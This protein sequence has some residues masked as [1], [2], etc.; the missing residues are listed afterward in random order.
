MPL[1]GN[2]NLFHIYSTAHV[3]LGIV[4]TVF[5]VISLIIN[6]FLDWGAILNVGRVLEDSLVHILSIYN[7]VGVSLVYI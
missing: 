7:C 6:P 5:F 3:I 1:L 2:T 4:T